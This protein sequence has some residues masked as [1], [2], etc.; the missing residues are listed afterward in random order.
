[1]AQNDFF[2]SLNKTKVAHLILTAETEDFD[3]ETTKQWQDEGFHTAYVP[4]LNGGHEYIKRIHNTADAFGVGDYYAIV[5]KYQ[6]SIP[7]HDDKSR[8]TE[9]ARGNSIR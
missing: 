3:E 6:H 7:P 5:G 8:L 1:M 9:M 2:N 4:L